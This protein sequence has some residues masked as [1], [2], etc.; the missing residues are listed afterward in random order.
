MNDF[1]KN[2]L[3][4]R[5]SEAIE[6]EGLRASEAGLLIG[7]RHK[8]YGCMICNPK[9]MMKVSK[10]SYF[11]LQRWANSGESIKDYASKKGRT[12]LEDIKPEKIPPPPPPP[13]EEP[14]ETPTPSREK[15]SNN[16]LRSFLEE[17]K[18][19]DPSE[20]VDLTYVFNK[21]FRL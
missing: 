15:M 13:E 19:L 2:K 10:A 17:W 7:F 5:F 3:A 11:I 1:V 20:Q 12:T 4:K 9:Q 21:L 18:D 8:N 6:H 14:D 16:K